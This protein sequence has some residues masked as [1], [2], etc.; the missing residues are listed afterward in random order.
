MRAERQDLLIFNRVPKVGSQ[1]LFRIM[2]AMAAVNNFTSYKDDGERVRQYGETT[3]II[4]HNQRIEFC[5]MFEQFNYPA[6]YTKHIAFIDFEELES[7]RG[8]KKYAK[9]FA[10][11]Q[12][13]F[14]R[15]IYIN[16]VRE[17][18]DRIISWY[19]Y[20]RA[21]WYIVE[22]ETNGKIGKTSPSFQT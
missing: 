3:M 20:T 7:L 6:S 1:T 4:C 8:N 22:K 13:T 21:P 5:K 10:S 2:N 12:Y 14:Q 9:Q 11:F 17:P 18:V 15:P 19:Y 16:M